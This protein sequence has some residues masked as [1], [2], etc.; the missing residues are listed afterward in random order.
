MMRAVMVLAEVGLD[1]RSAKTSE[2]RVAVCEKSCVAHMQEKNAHAYTTCH[3]SQTNR[4]AREGKLNTY[5][6]WCVRNA[7]SPSDAPSTAAIITD[8][9]TAKRQAHKQIGTGRG[10]EGGRQRQEKEEDHK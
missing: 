2:E 5:T 9:V 1:V 10:R 4:K 6:M 7:C 3:G 8:S